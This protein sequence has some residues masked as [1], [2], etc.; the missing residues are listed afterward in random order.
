MAWARKLPS[1]RWQASYRDTSGKTKTAGSFIRKSDA[2]SAGEEEERKLRRGDWIDPALRKTP[3]AEYAE[4]Y[5]AVTLNQDAPTKIRDESLLHN[6]LVPVFGPRALGAIETG[7]VRAWIAELSGVLAPSTVS[8]CY[9]I[10]A[11]I[12]RNAEDD[13]LISRSPCSRSVKL[14]RQTS[15]K[16]ASRWL[17]LDEL[18]HLASTIGAPYRA[19]VLTMGYMGLRYGEAV[20]IKR[21]RLDLLRG[22]LEVAG[23]LREVRGHQEYVGFTKTAAGLRKLPLPASLLDDLRRHIEEHSK[24]ADFV[25][26]GRDGAPL[27]KAWVRRHFT[28]AAEKAG[29]SPLTPHHLRH[30]CASLLIDRGGHAKDIQEWLGHSSYQVTMDCYGHLFPERQ[31]QLAESLDAMRLASGAR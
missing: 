23:Q 13:G 25:F 22:T 19:L 17:T 21:D 16:R 26:S 14:P 3:F 18:E 4:R 1:G 27:R 10:L 30:T 5:M 20:G 2:T 24:N 7:D 8:R 15:S 9:Q 29:L 11:R 28:P 12:L 6:H 31:G